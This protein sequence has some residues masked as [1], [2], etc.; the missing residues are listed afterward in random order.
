MQTMKAAALAI[1]LVIAV[2]FGAYYF[3][4]HSAVPREATGFVLSSRLTPEMVLGSA[5]A[6]I[7]EVVEVC[8]TKSWL[9]FEGRGRALIVGSNRYHYGVAWDPKTDV[10]ATPVAELPGT[11]DIEI[12]VRRVSI[13]MDPVPTIRAWVLDQSLLI[14]M[15]RE[16]STLKDLMLKRMSISATNNLSLADNQ[17]IFAEAIRSHLRAIYANEPSKLRN[18]TVRLGN[19]AI[20]PAI[21]T[22]WDNECLVRNVVL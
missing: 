5:N 15:T 20:P 22:R 4:K 2:G 10:K 8:P 16:T 7:T 18:I 13:T 9:I 11:F 1:V 6:N 17:S 19:G 21:P 14:D 12:T 3:G